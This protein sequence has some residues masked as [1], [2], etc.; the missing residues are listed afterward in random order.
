MS[1][2]AVPDFRTT[3]PT[4]ALAAYVSSKIYQLQLGY[5]NNQSAAVGKLAQLRRAVATE[6]GTQSEI[7]DLLF[8]G[9]PV[10]L[11]G[12]GDQPSRAELSTHACITLYAVH[13]QSQRTPMHIAGDSLGAAVGQ[14][15][16]KLAVGDGASNPGVIR[17]FQ[18]LGT[19]TTFSETLHHAR[20]LIT[21]L[22]SAQ[23]S[24]DYGRLAA[25]L[26]Q[27]QDTTR[28]GTVRLQWG[29]G[30]YN[31]RPDPRPDMAIGDPAAAA[32]IINPREETL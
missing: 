30:F 29:R 10:Q 32:D 21:Q 17:R 19:A 5:L 18:A 1:P 9:M 8:D 12:R 2:T 31:A 24:M 25:D 7:W 22:R 26:Y 28:S 15:A 20:G 14:L 4:E 13:Q 11:V 23:I 6:P 3:R 16:R 27:L